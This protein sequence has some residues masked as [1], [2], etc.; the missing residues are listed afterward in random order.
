[1]VYQG[2]GSDILPITSTVF[3]DPA[4]TNFQLSWPTVGYHTADYNMDGKVTYQGFGSDIIPITQSVF[5]NPLN[6]AFEL[7]FPVVEQLP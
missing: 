6:G 2:S 7:T 5:S 3:S 1:V 4:N